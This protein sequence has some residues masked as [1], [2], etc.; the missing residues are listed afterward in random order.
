MRPADVE[1]QHTRDRGIKIHSG[2]TE[3]TLTHEKLP[4]AVLRAAHEIGWAN[5]FDHLIDVVDWSPSREVPLTRNAQHT[6][7]RITRPLRGN[8][9]SE[10]ALQQCRNPAPRV[11]LVA[12]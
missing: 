11:P 8:G 2:G 12:P 3:L 5:M 4:T 9:V 6:A 1:R 7:E 10:H